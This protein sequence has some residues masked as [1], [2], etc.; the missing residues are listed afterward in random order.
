MI[1]RDSELCC[2]ECENR[3][4]FGIHAG[5]TLVMRTELTVMSEQARSNRHQHESIAK[6]ALSLLS[7]AEPPL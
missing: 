7:L 3:T 1:S 6:T 2:R 5:D 4:C